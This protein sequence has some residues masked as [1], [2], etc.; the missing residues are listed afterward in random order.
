MS[1]SD[2]T[3]IATEGEPGAD[4]DEIDAA[5]TTPKEE[6]PDA[7]WPGPIQDPPPLFDQ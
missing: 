3:K 5:E 7:E 1:E 6:A 4:T 2:T